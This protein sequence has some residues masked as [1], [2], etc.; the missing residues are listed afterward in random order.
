MNSIDDVLVRIE[1]E[2]FYLIPAGPKPPNPSE[3]IASEN[4]DK[5]L[6][7]L[8]KRFDYIIIDT[9]PVGLVTDAMILMQ[10]ADLS[11]L[12]TR[13]LVT[14]KDSLRYFQKYV[15]EFHIKS[16]GI[17][18]NGAKDSSAYGYGGYGKYGSYK[19]AGYYS[20]D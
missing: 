3:M 6:A 17:V 2:D 19:S 16:V 7:E 15:G 1:D 9:P 5:V 18:L 4:I 13:V 20:E 11:L 10:K 8:K 12:V 14:K